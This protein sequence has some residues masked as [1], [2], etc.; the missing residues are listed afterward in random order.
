MDTTEQLLAVS[1]L[2]AR[3][4]T[5]TLIVRFL[6]DA[7]ERRT[8]PHYRSGP[9][10]KLYK[11]QRVEQV[12]ASAEFREV[13]DTR[14]SKRDAAQKALATK[15]QKITNYVEH[16]KIEV[17]QLA[18]DEL[19]RRACDNYNFRQWDRPN[20]H[21]FCSADKNS[22]PLFLERICVNYLRHCLTKYEA[23]LGEIAGKVGVRDAYTEI[24]EKV[25]DAIAHKYDWLRNECWR[26][27]ERNC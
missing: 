3:G 23:H 26:Q 1:Q 24:K 6:G 11:M 7:D 14:K 16:L 27:R 21:D 18:K 2:K 5:D 17:P 22:D 25:L 15:K 12:E 20:N 19:I 4:W 9:P 10:M 13:Q 8:N